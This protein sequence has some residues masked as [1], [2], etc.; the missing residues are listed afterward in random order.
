[1]TPLLTDGTPSTG[2]AP[3]VPSGTDG[4]DG[5]VGAVVPA[6]GEA[7]TTTSVLR[8]ILMLRPPVRRRRGLHA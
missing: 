6:D 4:A 3:A 1:M 8:T 2:T 5:A 7:A